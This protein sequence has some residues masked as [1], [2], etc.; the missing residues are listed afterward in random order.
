[1]TTKWDG[2]IEK[3]EAKLGEVGKLP[4]SARGPFIAW[5]DDAE[6]KFKT[7]REKLMAEFNTISGAEFL[8][9]SWGTPEPKNN[10]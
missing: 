8:T 2:R 6:A 5:G 4:M 7:I 10:I 9:L 1:M 3:V